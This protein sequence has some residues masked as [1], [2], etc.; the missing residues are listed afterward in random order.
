MSQELIANILTISFKA[1][2]KTVGSNKLLEQKK[3]PYNLLKV[4]K[5]FKTMSLMHII[6]QEMGKTLLLHAI[7]MKFS[8]TFNNYQ[9]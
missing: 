3:P 4:L 9:I 1:Q 5:A 6:L 2:K 8:I 7:S